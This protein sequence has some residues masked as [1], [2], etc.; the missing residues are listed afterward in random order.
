M[1]EKYKDIIFPMQLISKPYLII[2]VDYN[3]VD[4]QGY[5]VDL[6]ISEYNLSNKQVRIISKNLYTGYMKILIIGK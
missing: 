3:S 2:P 4:Y 1:D 6:A 5:D